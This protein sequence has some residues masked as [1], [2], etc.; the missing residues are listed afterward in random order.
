[1]ITARRRGR[2]RRSSS[3]GGARSRAAPGS[4]EPD[5]E[6]RQGADEERSGR[7]R[8]QRVEDDVLRALVDHRAEHDRDE[9]EERASARPRRDRAS[10]ARPAV[11]VIPERDTPGIS[12]STCAKPIRKPFLTPTSSRA[13]RSGEPV[14]DPEQDTEDGERDRDLPGLAELLL[15]EALAQR[16]RRSPPGWS[17]RR[18][19]RRCARPAVSMLRRRS[20]PTQRDDVADDVAPEVDDDRDQRPEVERDVERLVERRVRLEVVPVGDPGDEDQVPRRRDRQQLVAP[21][22]TPSTSACQ[23]DR[24]PA[25]SPTRSAASTTATA[26]M[27]A[28]AR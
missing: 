22:T 5:R 26:K 27:I 12:A 4:R 16:L 23:S 15:D 25:F 17:P 24:R 14:G 19:P 28:A 2:A 18:R 21:W 8:R 3:R 11:I 20:E 10:T 9:Q 7:S 13:A 1:M 6:R